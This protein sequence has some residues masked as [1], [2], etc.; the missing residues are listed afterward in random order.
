M[1]LTES[2]AELAF[3]EEAR[4]WL[5][6]NVPTDLRGRGFASSRG[7]VESVVRLRAWQRRLYG[8]G[9]VGMD[10]PTEYGGRGASIVEQIIFY[11]EMSRA[12]A[13]QPLNRSGL[14]MLGPTIM[15]HGTPAQ[16]GRHL[17]K[18][19]TAEEIWCQGFSEPN[20]GSD[21]ANLQT[22]R[23]PTAT[24][25]STARKSDLHGAWRNGAYS[26]CTDAEGPS[27]GITFIRWLE[28]PASPPSVRNLRRGS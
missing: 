27:P 22:W 24:L 25:V 23:R 20:A 17:A 21:L 5:A 15:R 12:E 11:E 2:P 3:R 10:W 8:A 19:L 4:A 13:P 28:D 14:S 26:S 9:Y 1:D 7:D 16:R 18:I 6:D